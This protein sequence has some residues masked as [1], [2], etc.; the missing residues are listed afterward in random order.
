VPRVPQRPQPVDAAILALA[1]HE[2]D[3]PEGDPVV[4]RTLETLREKSLVWVVRGGRA[5]KYEHRLAEKLALGAPEIAVMCVLML[6]GA[7]TPGEIRGR[8]GRLHAFAGLEEVESALEGLTRTAPPLVTRSP[9]LPGTK[10][11]RF[12][13]LL[14]GEPVGEATAFPSRSESPEPAAHPEGERIARL[15][16]E[17]EAL[18][19]ELHLIRGQ[20]AEFRERFE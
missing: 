20:L 7:Q 4:A 12:A 2:R 8:T 6:R 16:S 5:P 13:H 19:E 10:E 3:R 1:S 14:G 9:R 11:A 17:I 15:E 18:R